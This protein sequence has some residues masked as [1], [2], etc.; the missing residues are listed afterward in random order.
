MQ[1]RPLIYAPFNLNKNTI[2]RHFNK[3]LAFIQS[4]GCSEMHKTCRHMGRASVNFHINKMSISEQWYQLCMYT[5]IWTF[6]YAC[7]FCINYCTLLCAIVHFSF[8]FLC[9]IMEL[10]CLYI[11]ALTFNNNGL[12]LIISHNSH[13]CFICRR[14]FKV[15]AIVSHRSSCLLMSVS[16]IVSGGLPYFL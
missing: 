5:R 11:C 14:R 8:H 12:L 15:S 4:R 7:S 6:V 3:I 2:T 13:T 10:Y 1:F 9:N 16:Y